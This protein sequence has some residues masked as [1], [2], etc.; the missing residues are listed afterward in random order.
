MGARFVAA[1]LV[2]APFGVWKTALAHHSMVSILVGAVA[3]IFVAA[4]VGKATGIAI[5]RLRLG[6]ALKQLQRAIAAA[7][8]KA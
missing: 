7:R 4:A 2:A 6:R 3:G 8:R 5:A 1:Y